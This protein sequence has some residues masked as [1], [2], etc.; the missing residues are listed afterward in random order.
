MA[1]PSSAV[2][3]YEDVPA[4][5]FGADVVQRVRCLTQLEKDEYDVG[6]WK[7]DPA[8]PGGMLYDAHGSRGR[9]L[10]MACVN[11]DG[12]A[13]ADAATWNRFRTDVGERL[14]DAAQRLSG[15]SATVEDLKKALSAVRAGASHTT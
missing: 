2:L 6:F 4:P 10:A 13:T 3:P 9:L 8:K 15:L 1:E 5:E 7:A 14:F 11:E 12:T